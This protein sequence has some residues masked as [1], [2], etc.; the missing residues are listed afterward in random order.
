[1]RYNISIRYLTSSELLH[2]CVEL[3]K[4]KIDYHF[5]FIGNSI[6]LLAFLTPYHTLF[7]PTNFNQLRIESINQC[8]REGKALIKEAVAE[9]YLNI[10]APAAH[11]I[12]GES[13]GKLYINSNHSP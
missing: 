8:Y 4:R 3:K 13:S 6:I 10:L 9:V 7:S 5:G 12:R 11:Y 1:M 2:K